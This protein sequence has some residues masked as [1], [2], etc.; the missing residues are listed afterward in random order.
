MGVKTEG[1]GTVQ[2]KMLLDNNGFL[3]LSHELIVRPNGNPLQ[4]RNFRDSGIEPDKTAPERDFISEYYLDNTPE[5]EDDSLGID[6]FRN[7]DKAISEEQ[8]RMARELVREMIDNP[9]LQEK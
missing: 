1:K 9:G 2:K 6:F 4:D 3:F 7:L 5:D 8:M